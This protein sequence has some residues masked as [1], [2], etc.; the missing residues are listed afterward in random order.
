MFFHL[1]SANTIAGTAAL[2]TFQT[3]ANAL[4]TFFELSR[5]WSLRTGIG[6]IVVITVTRT[7]HNGFGNFCVQFVEINKTNEQLRQF[8][9]AFFNVVCKTD[10]L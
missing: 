3:L 7:R 10:E 2:E 6:I 5:V 1:R 8:H 9:L 4:K